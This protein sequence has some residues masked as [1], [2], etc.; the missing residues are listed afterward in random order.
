MNSTNNDNGESLISHLEAL[1]QTLLRCV[2]SLA[3]MLIPMLFAAP[4]CLNYFIKLIIGDNNVVLNYFSPAEVFLIQIKMAFVL[5]LIICFPYIAKQLW[6]FF[7]PALYEHER[8]FIRSIVFT[9]S[10]LFVFGVTFCLFLILPLIIRF[11]M[12][13]ATSDIQAVFGISN[14]INL[15][16]WLAVSFGLMFQF[17]LVT[18][19]LIRSGILSYETI[20]S[21][22][23]FV[24]VGILVLAAVLTPPD[25]VSQLMLFTPTYLLFEL[26]LLFSKLKGNKENE[27]NVE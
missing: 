9:S 23:P 10:F 16:L 21:Q 13:F 24:V 22:R 7:V 17:P 3:V 18:Y 4:K 19:S 11:G 14:V 6:N 20:S 27:N 5:D 1:R 12:S 25:I 26:G 8:K 2:I 15:S